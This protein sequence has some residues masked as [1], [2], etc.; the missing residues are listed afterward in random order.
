M[1]WCRFSNLFDAVVVGGTL[2][3]E[4]AQLETGIHSDHLR[5]DL[6]NLLGDGLV[7]DGD[8]VL[9]LGVDL[10][11][12]VE[13]ESGLNLARACYILYQHLVQ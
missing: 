8:Q 3:G 7:V 12:L 4:T 2:A 1:K 11:G 6:Q 5:Q 9:G 10:E 13:G